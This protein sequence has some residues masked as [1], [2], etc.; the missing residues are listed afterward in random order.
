VE[1]KM[2]DTVSLSSSKKATKPLYT[3]ETDLSPEE[4]ARLD[5]VEQ[6]YIKHPENFI[7]LDDF[8]AVKRI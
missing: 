2:S 3:L 5:E 7:S 6:E 1:T 4:L 8:L